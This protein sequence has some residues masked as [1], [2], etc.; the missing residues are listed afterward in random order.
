MMN[1]SEFQQLNLAKPD[2]KFATDLFSLISDNREYLS[3]WLAWPN[4]VTHIKDSEY[5]IKN[6][7]KEME[8][9]TAETY[10]ILFDMKPIGTVSFNK[11][12]K[13]N[14]IGYVGYWISEKYQGKG[15]VKFA[16][17]FLLQRG[18]YELM[19]N[20]VVIRCAVGNNKSESIPLKFAFKFE[21]IARENEL[22]NG[23]FIDHKIYS[24]LKNEFSQGNSGRNEA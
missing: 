9:G 20:K 24:L 12:D 22:V 5:F 18:F 23:I 13:Q 6:A 14:K 2:L 17:N 10:I 1:N 4:Y 7:I 21:G 3:V 19:L 16:V 11:I 8:E 15:F